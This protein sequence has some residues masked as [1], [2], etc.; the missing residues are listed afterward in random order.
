AALQA[1]TINNARVLHAE[2]KLGSID[3]GKL[4]DI[5]IL[6]ADPLASIQNS[7]KIFRVIKDGKIYD[8]RSL[9]NGALRK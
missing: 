6:D 9:L 8:P 3:P 4:A 1:A 2:A 7:R 5:V